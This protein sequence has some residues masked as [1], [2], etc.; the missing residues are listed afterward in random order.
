[1]KTNLILVVS[2]GFSARS[3]PIAWQVHKKGLFDEYKDLRIETKPNEDTLITVE[4]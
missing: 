3:G 4:P 1:M 2:L